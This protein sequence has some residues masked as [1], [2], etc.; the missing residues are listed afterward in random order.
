MSLKKKIVLACLA[1]LVLLLNYFILTHDGGANGTAN[2][3]FSLNGTVSDN[4]QVYYSDTTDFA[5]S[6]QKTVGYE[7]GDIG[8]D[9]TMEFALPLTTRYVRID[10]GAAEAK[11][12]VSDARFVLGDKEQSFDASA[13]LRDNDIDSFESAG[14]SF[15]VTT[16]SGDPFVVFEQGPDQIY[17]QVLP[18]LRTK[19]TVKNVIIA[20][21]LDLMCAAAFVFRKKFS[22]LPMEL[23]QNRVLIMQLARNDF[24]TKYAG[25]ADLISIGYVK[26]DIPMNYWVLCPHHDLSQIDK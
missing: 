5:P 6:A 7:S 25:Q 3:I 23:I 11:Y 8:K 12:S 10:F 21:L 4:I 26:D 24:K 13:V 1:V 19:N 9:V 17:A 20:V 18:G 14:G 22:T 15:T 16:K 2:L